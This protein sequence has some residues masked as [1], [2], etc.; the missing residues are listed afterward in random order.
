M[1][2]DIN[3]GAITPTVD[4]LGYAGFP[5]PDALKDLFKLGGDADSSNDNLVADRGNA[6]VVGAL[7]YEEQY[8]SF[9][10]ASAANHMLMATNENELADYTRF[11][12]ARQLTPITDSTTW[13]GLV[14]R[15]NGTV[16][17]GL[18]CANV[19]VQADGAAP[20]WQA[21]IGTPAPPHAQFHFVAMTLDTA[22]KTIQATWGFGGEV[23][24]SAPFVDPA[25][26]VRNAGPVMIGG[27]QLADA[28][29]NP[30]VDIAGVGQLDRVLTL[31]EFRKV[32]IWAREWAGVEVA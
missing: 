32:Y 5:V 12:I 9:L 31:A 8:I 24:Q 20:Q 26:P 18:L 13:R 27:D 14:G 2:I 16:S 10:L 6:S 22:A 28:A 17:G 15:L 1:G 25:A 11:A 3:N 19:A 21:G 29:V 30:K 4:P 23:Y 7:T